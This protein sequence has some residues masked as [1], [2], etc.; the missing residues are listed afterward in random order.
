MPVEAT[1]SL[2]ML[3]AFLLVL[4][5][6]SGVFAFLPFPGF[7]NSPLAPRIVASL[8]LSVALLPL[9]P[10]VTVQPSL[11]MIAGWIAAEAAFGIMIGIAVAFFAEGFLL[12]MQVLGLQAGY[13]YAST[14]DPS[15]EADTGVLQVLAQIAANL[16]F[17]VAGL[18]REVI[19]AMAGNLERHPPGTFA[20]LASV[21]TLVRLGGQVFVTGLRLALPVVALLL[22]VDITLALTGRIHARLQLLSLAFPAKMLAALAMLASLAVLYPVI[23]TQSAGRMLGSIAKLVR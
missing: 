3:Y 11:G 15:S 16:L 5:R 8:A 20:S 21:D 13:S 9:W 17:F 12:A 10:R 18:D 6:V 14:I 22:L 7:R 4:A 1:L 19:R 23:Y 2:P